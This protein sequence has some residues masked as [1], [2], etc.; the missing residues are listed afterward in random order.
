VNDESSEKDG[1]SGAK[2][3]LAG[4]PLDSDLP[5][6]HFAGGISFCV[7]RPAGFHQGKMAQLVR[8]YGRIAL[9]EIK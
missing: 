6:F 7:H 1:A 3:L 5:W 8:S 9:A 2:V 4:S